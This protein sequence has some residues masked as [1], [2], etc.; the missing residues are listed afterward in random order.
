MKY[1]GI[2]FDDW[3][4]DPE[5]KTAWA[6]MCSACAKQTMVDERYLDD[7]CPDGAECGVC[8]CHNEA[9]YYY[10]MPMKESEAQEACLNETISEPKFMYVDGRNYFY[11]CFAD[12]GECTGVNL[13]DGENG[14]FI[15]TFDTM[16]D[17]ENYVGWKGETA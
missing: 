13:Y 7:A 3:T 16:V 6:Y 8:G 1:K 14:M 10:D 5:T 12:H 17:M 2:T 11:Q 4:Y 9:E 15:E